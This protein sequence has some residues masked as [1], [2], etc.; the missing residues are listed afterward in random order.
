MTVLLAGAAASWAL[1]YG[2]SEEDEP[3]SEP[4]QIGVGYYATD[5]RLTGTGEDGRILYRVAAATVAQSQGDGSVDLQRVT[6]DYDPA[7]RTPWNLRADAGRI[8]PGGKLIELAGNVVAE[9]RASG[10][11]AATIHTDYLEFDTST[12]VAATDREV[13][14]DYAGSAVRATGMRVTLA[15]NRVELLSQVKGT[16][17]P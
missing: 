14:I 13:I 7:A 5:A 16:Y 11:P 9:T 2:A 6:I 3:A 4:A 1:M 17:V 10:A 15:E 12:D 8:P